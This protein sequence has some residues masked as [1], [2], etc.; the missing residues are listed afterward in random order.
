MRT[1]TVL[2]CALAALA[3]ALAVLATPA[4]LAA[5]ELVGPPVP[6]PS[7]GS[8]SQLDPHLAARPG[9]GFALV[10][11][12][13]ADPLEPAEPEGGLFLTRFDRRGVRL[14]DALPY[15]AS[16][17]GSSVTL[18]RVSAVDPALLE[19]FSVV[20]SSAGAVPRV[21]RR[22]W[23]TGR[24]EVEQP[25]PVVVARCPAAS[26]I[27]SDLA[28]DAVRSEEAPGFGGGAVYAAVAC[29]DPDGVDGIFL[30][31]QPVDGGAGQLVRVDQGFGGGATRVALAVDPRGRALVA[32]T[33]DDPR[34]QVRSRLLFPLQEGEDFRPVELLGQAVDGS[35]LEAIA[36]A[37]PDGGFVVGWREPTIVGGDSRVVV[38]QVGP[39]GAPL[40]PRRPISAPIRDATLPTG[41]R[42]G[43]A[44]AAG[45][46]GRWA[47]SWVEP[48]AGVQDQDL[49]RFQVYD[50]RMEP[51]PGAPLVISP[52]FAFPA[53]ADSRI[54]AP[55]VAWDTTGGAALVVWRGS[56]PALPFPK[57]RLV[58]QLV[59]VAP[60]AAPRDELCVMRGNRL[61]CA[62]L[63][64]PAPDPALLDIRFGNGL[65][66]GLLPLL[67]DLDG[68][69]RDDLCIGRDGVIRC[70]LAGDGVLAEAGFAFGNRFVDLAGGDLGG[71]PRDRG[72][73]CSRDPEQSNRFVCD[74]D[75]AGT[76]GELALAFGP[77]D[78]RP[79][80][81]DADGDGRDELCLVFGGL[82]RCDLAQNG[83]GAELFRPVNGALTN[84]LAT[85]GTPLLADVDGDGRD[86][87]CVAFEGRFTCDVGGTLVQVV[88]PGGADFAGGDVPL[89]GNVDG[90]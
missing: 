20:S 60:T 65:S 3:G 40:G 64:E 44:L 89:A 66:A 69:G 13:D 70:D 1:S 76:P 80:L 16:G 12:E 29:R 74:T 11:R 59:D 50:H 84:P 58:A 51:L 52:R 48:L 79:F 71:L 17:A 47:V 28:V 26:E 2:S 56:N 88:P 37:G 5:A 42:T 75:Q 81:G 31:R 23:R 27:V 25:R 21:E 19:L 7:A 36:L 62:S 63:A 4:G 34:I 68:D 90:L 15:A 57:V 72:D 33:T 9:G 30:H 24:A 73:V 49:L 35:S 10:W 8:D 85:G 54:T 61:R 45:P 38:R 41:E 86:D 78:S 6:V 87:L 32:W 22:T 14:T 77:G 67:T 39:G 18:P 83:G 43:P 82:L 55:A 53:T 46:G